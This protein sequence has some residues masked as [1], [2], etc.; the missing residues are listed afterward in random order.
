M[1]ARPGESDAVALSRLSAIGARLAEAR[2]AWARAAYPAQP[3]DERVAAMW[4][5]TGRGAQGSFAHQ[6]AWQQLLARPVVAAFRQA[7]STRPLPPHVRDRALGDLRDTLFYQ[8]VGGQGFAELA[9]FTLETAPGGPVAPL[10]DVLSERSRSRAARCVSARGHW[11]QT[12]ALALPA[13]GATERALLVQA[14]PR[15]PE[16]WIELHCALRLLASWA[17]S[18]GDDDRDWSIVTQNQGRSRG[19]LRALA[20]SEP[21][22]ALAERVAALPALAERTRAAARRWAW[23]WAWEA[24]ATDFA[25]DLDRPVVRPCVAEAGVA[26]LEAEELEIVETWLLLV[27]LRGRGDTV[28][29]WAA[30]GRGDSDGTWGRLLLELPADL[31]EA[32]G[33]LARV[34]AALAAGWDARV[35][36]VAPVLRRV[37]G[38]SE[39]RALK[40]AFW[41]V[42][43]P[44]WHVAVAHPRAGF[45]TFVRNARDW[46]ARGSETGGPLPPG[47]EA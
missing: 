46:V 21:A 18:P 3:A 37:A 32:D 22:A 44:A 26:A 33:G 9:A 35:A 10:F 47:G 38:L 7:L 28:R 36:S 6:G 16:D 20:A 43:G 30:E 13:A 24:L 11:P 23:S 31:R 5:A 41:D 1:P 14:D 12:L 15:D 42:V 29:R 27:I 25:F 34:R 17:E 4:R 39:G 45:P 8:L 19:R 40:R 2:E